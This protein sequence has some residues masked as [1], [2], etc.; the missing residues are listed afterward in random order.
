[1]SQDS[2][3][4]PVFSSVIAPLHS[5]LSLSFLFGLFIPSSSVAVTYMMLSGIPGLF[6]IIVSWSFLCAFVLLFSTCLSCL[7]K[8][9]TPSKKGFPMVHY[10]LTVIIIIIIRTCVC[11]PGFQPHCMG[12][13]ASVWLQ[14]A[15]AS[16][17]FSLAI[18]AVWGC[19]AGWT[20]LPNWWDLI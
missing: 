8:S 6:D 14:R 19:A 20:L 5:H 3:S 18:M 4:L 15:T 13:H 1:M 16:W 7:S 10:T 9:Q 12:Q 2:S 17:E 11:Q